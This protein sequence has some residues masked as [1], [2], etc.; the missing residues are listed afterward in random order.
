VV[1]DASKAGLQRWAHSVDGVVP[2][3]TAL[4]RAAPGPGALLY[5]VVEAA[6]LVGGE[7]ESEVRVADVSHVI[8]P[9]AVLRRL[10]GERVL[11]ALARLDVA[12]G[13]VWNTNPGLWQRYDKPWDGVGG[14]AGTSK[15]IGT[16]GTTYG[17]P[18]RYD[19]TLYRVTI[20]THGAQVGWTVESICDD[21]L[22][23][24]GLTL[25]SCTRAELANPPSSDPFK[26][27]TS[28]T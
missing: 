25:A 2:D 9:A 5:A 11:T 22:G 1:I 18:T 10:E 7:I 14:M 12:D 28:H 13:G 23:Y 21:A 17:A 16:I 26:S 20:T 27:D 8:R 6:G 19:I 24:A 3:G 4:P 15:L